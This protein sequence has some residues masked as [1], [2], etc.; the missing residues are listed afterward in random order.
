MALDKVTISML[1]PTL[2]GGNYGHPVNM[3][4]KSQGNAATNYNEC[5]A[6]CTG[7]QGID[8]ALASITT[9]GCCG[10]DW[11][12]NAVKNGGTKLGKPYEGNG[13][14]PD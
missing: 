5:V 1:N 14:V 9:S 12:N 11:S 7:I 8:K 3:G 10:Q 4:Q 2:D 6:S 13:A